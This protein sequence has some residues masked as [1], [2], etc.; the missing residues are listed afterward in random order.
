MWVLTASIVAQ[1][2]GGQGRIGIEAMI[3]NIFE[4]PTHVRMLRGSKPLKPSVDCSVDD[5]Q[6]CK[7]LLCGATD[8]VDRLRRMAEHQNGAHLMT[9][10]L[11]HSHLERSHTQQACACVQGPQTTCCFPGIQYLPRPPPAPHPKVYAYQQTKR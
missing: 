11:L 1:R 3:G 4:D 6:L 7:N 5:L 2:S 8:M 9:M 10:A